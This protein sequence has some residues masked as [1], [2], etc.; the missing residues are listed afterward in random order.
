MFKANIAVITLAM[1]ALAP[2]SFAQDDDFP[3]HFEDADQFMSLKAQI[4]LE[5]IPDLDSLL[6]EYTA[7]ELKNF[8][9]RQVGGYPGKSDPVLF[10]ES[11]RA[12][13]IART[14]FV[15]RYLDWILEQN[16]NRTGLVNALETGLP[17]FPPGTP[18]EFVEQIKRQ[19]EEAT[20]RERVQ[21]CVAALALVPPRDS[22][23]Y[24]FTAEI[25]GREDQL[26]KNRVSQAQ[27]FQR[28]LS[29]V[30]AS[31]FFKDPSFTD[32]KL[33]ART[34]VDDLSAIDHESAAASDYRAV[35]ARLN[36]LWRALGTGDWTLLNSTD[37]PDTVD[38]APPMGL[39]WIVSRGHVIDEKSRFS[40]GD[41]G[42][43]VVLQGRTAR[44]Q[45]Q[46][47]IPW[48]GEK[49]PTARSLSLAGI[50]PAGTIL[51]VGEVRVRGQRG[52]RPG[53]YE[54]LSGGQP[55]GGFQ[56]PGFTMAGSATSEVGLGRS[57][58]FYVESAWRGQGKQA[59]KKFAVYDIDPNSWRATKVV[60]LPELQDFLLG[61][62]AI[63][64]A[65][66]ANPL[67]AAV[68][69]YMSS[70]DMLLRY[71][72]QFVW[73]QGGKYHL[74]PELKP[75]LPSAGVALLATYEVREDLVLAT[76]D[77]SS[78]TGKSHQ[79]VAK[80][81]GSDAFQWRKSGLRPFHGAAVRPLPFTNPRRVRIWDSPDTT[82]EFTTS[83]VELST[84]SGVRPL[85]KIGESV[86][87]IG[88]LLEI[89]DAAAS[90][91]GLA[92]VVGGRFEGSDG[93]RYG[94]CVLRSHDP[95]N[96]SDN[97]VPEHT[98]R[99]ALVVD[100]SRG[101]RVSG[102]YA[103]LYSAKI[104]R[105][106][107]AGFCVSDSGVA[108]LRKDPASF[109][110]V[111]GEEARTIP[112]T[113]PRPV[114]GL[115]KAEHV[116]FKSEV[117]LNG[118]S[119]L[120]PEP[121]EHAGV[122]EGGV[123]WGTSSQELAYLKDDL[124]VETLFNANQLLLGM[125]DARVIE[126]KDFRHAASYRIRSANLYSPDRWIVSIAWREQP[127]V[128]SEKRVLVWSKGDSGIHYLPL[129][130]SSGKN[131][132][133]QDCMGSS[134]TDGGKSFHTLMLTATGVVH[135]TLDVDPKGNALLTKKR[136]EDFPMVLKLWTDNAV[137]LRSVDTALR[138]KVYSGKNAQVLLNSVDLR[139][140]LL[141]G[142]LVAESAGKFETIAAPNAELPGVGVVHRIVQAA[143]SP[144]GQFVSTVLEIDGDGA[145]S[146]QRVIAS[147]HR[148]APKT[149][150]N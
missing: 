82:V 146:K 67:D 16:R 35:Q 95:T 8:M 125:R 1:L 40:V 77:W 87:G 68:L 85:L 45:A 74:L 38:T 6:Q 36:I 90:P 143:V 75:H 105:A 83:R 57:G 66:Y 63:T 7:K 10:R 108:L 84:A 49:T 128:S 43:V 60:G 76:F 99:P 135:A 110:L 92:I 80:S 141:D 71:G 116:V 148:I 78:G 97:E 44:L 52:G 18:A 127:R 150:G 30:A 147:F 53:R 81:S 26:R 91:N 58:R 113:S 118:I 14:A 131:L 3:N 126:S 41:R 132:A 13:R 149:I 96:H 139:L 33:A 4:E 59:G 61:E 56:V 89:S 130:E 17:K 69:D 140:A 9:N 103:L 24:D 107:G 37:A 122:S 142:A 27:K 70:S 50:D 94:V 111:G 46:S 22:F 120:F 112:A 145:G 19:L 21:D 65:S 106:H 79:L 137:A 55:I 42:D 119:T 123:I 93:T 134:F 2:F 102:S 51:L 114:Q 5:I 39:R 20:S 29:G 34:I 23:F 72:E 104:D 101:T 62:G 98:S 86:D 73:K 144:N 12:E 25:K 15:S 47:I 133:I 138:A 136:L 117:S 100:L 121:F 11:S 124:K 31:P 48:R 109:Q 54:V 115:T 32:Y 129:S 88:R 64:P 28:D